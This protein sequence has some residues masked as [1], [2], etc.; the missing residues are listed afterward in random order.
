MI[1]QIKKKGK[2]LGWIDYEK[3]IY[4]SKRTSDHFFIKYNG[5]A[6][7]IS[8]LNYLQKRKITLIEVISEGFGYLTTLQRF[9][10]RGIPHI[11]E[12]DNSDKQLVLSMD[13]WKRDNRNQKKINTLALLGGLEND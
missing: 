4:F 1:E 2:T 9:F 12:L 13:G 5:W 11:N 8:V 10:E 3:K 6:I 7:S